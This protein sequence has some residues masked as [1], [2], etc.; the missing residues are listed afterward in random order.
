MHHFVI[1]FTTKTEPQIYCYFSLKYSVI[2]DFPL[3]EETVIWKIQNKVMDE[4]I[5]KISRIFNTEKTIK[6]W[7]NDINAENI[8]YTNTMKTPIGSVKQFEEIKGKFRV[9]SSDYNP[10]SKFGERHS[11]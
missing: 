2:P 6:E 10:Y 7:L 5:F 4:G 3:N 1:K 9:Y 8:F 11:Q